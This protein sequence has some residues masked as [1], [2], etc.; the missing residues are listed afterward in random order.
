MAELAVFEELLRYVRWTANDALVLQ[1]LFPV[2]QPHTKLIAEQFYERIR[3]HPDAN[4]VFKDEAQVRRLQGTLQQWLLDMFRGPHDEAYFQQRCR[5]GTMH[6]KI[7]LPQRFMF[8]AM[9]LIRLNLQEIIINQFK[10]DNEKTAALGAVTKILDVELAIMLETFREALFSRLQRVEDLERSG[11]LSQLAAAEARYRSAIETAE[12]V[13]VVLDQDGRTVLWNKKAEQLTGYDKDE[14]L[15][16]APLDLLIENENART[17]I[18]R[19]QPGNPVVLEA[20]LRT[21]A[22]REC[23]LRWFVSVNQDPSTGGTVRHVLAVDLT[24]ARE[25]ERR[26]RNAERLAAVG[27][28]AAGLAHEIRNPLNAA[29]LHLAILERSLRNWASSPAEANEATQVVRGEL[30]RLSLLLTDFLEFAQP[31]ALNPSPQDI[32][33]LVLKVHD[34]VKPACSS[35]QIRVRFERTEKP[36][37]ANV[38]PERVHQV[39]L[40]L[41]QNAIDAVSTNAP[42]KPKELIL[43]VRLVRNMAEIDVEDSGPGFPAGAPI[44]DAFFT[45]KKSGTGLGLA[46]AHRIIDHHGGSLSVSRSQDRTTFTIKL[47]TLEDSSALHLLR[48]MSCSENLQTIRPL[49]AVS[50]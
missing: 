1:Q 8:A 18:L 15:A 6:A 26:A 13:F 22:G 10:N 29:S 38:D 14:M 25:S 17:A 49:S 35:S 50:R 31:R 42:T 2:V 41:V 20:A 37:P 23:W 3:E 19:A 43:R 28:L 9:A 33:N 12:V 5:I 11:L 30:K 4:K 47:P 16:M 46:I 40:N 32:N 24:D 48:L 21:K 7:G 27:L 45:T 34:L 44:F 39:L 36:V